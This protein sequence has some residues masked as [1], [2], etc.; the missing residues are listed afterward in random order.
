MALPNITYSTDLDLSAIQGTANQMQP[1]IRRL[2]SQSI[3]EQLK[4]FKRHNNVRISKDLLTAIGQEIVRPF[5]PDLPDTPSNSSKLGTVEKRTL[6]V[7][8][9]MIFV[10]QQP[11]SVR[12]TYLDKI[13]RLG[14][15]QKKFPFHQFFIELIAQQAMEDLHQVTWQGVLNGSGTAAV[16]LTNGFLKHITDAVSDGTISTGNG[17]LYQVTDST[18][19]TDPVTDYSESTI[20]DELR[21]QYDMLPEHVRERGNPVCYISSQYKRMYQDAYIAEYT[22]VTRDQVPMDRLDGTNLKLSWE[23]GMG[24][25]KRVI[26]TIPDNPNYGVD[27][28]NN[29][30]GKLKF[31]HPLNNPNWVAAQSKIALGFQ[32]ATFNSKVF[33]CNNFE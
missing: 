1:E 25:S 18:L 10:R 17:N 11:E 5:D 22:H 16:D 24:S 20:M 12:D 2:M 33:V 32:W 21:K 3:R 6:S 8:L 26:M 27:G 19:D 30:F 7:H 28:Q 31:F 4:R 14:I 29:E 9:G 23:S 15:P 13:E